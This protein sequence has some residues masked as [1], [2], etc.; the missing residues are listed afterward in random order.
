M[1]LK[2]N[3]RNHRNQRTKKLRLAKG[4][5]VNGLSPSVLTGLAQLG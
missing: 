4:V 2:D 5:G 3:M 1:Y